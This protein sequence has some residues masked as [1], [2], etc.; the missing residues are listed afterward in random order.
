MNSSLRARLVLF[1]LLIVVLSVT[2]LLTLPRPAEA[3]CSYTNCGNWLWNGCCYGGLRL[4]QYRQCCSSAGTL[5]C[6]QY[7]CT[8]ASCPT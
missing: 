4:Y 8:T 1:T 3:A 6:F 7:R 2:S 5:C